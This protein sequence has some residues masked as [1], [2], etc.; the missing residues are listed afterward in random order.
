[1]LTLNTH[2]KNDI[3]KCDIKDTLKM[4]LKNADI[5]KLDKFTLTNAES[6]EPLEK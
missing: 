4:T 2:Q 1:M 3:N 5:K 6:K